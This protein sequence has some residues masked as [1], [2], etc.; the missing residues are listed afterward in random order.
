MKKSPDPINRTVKFASNLFLWFLI[1]LSSYLYLLIDDIYNIKFSYASWW[2]EFYDI[3][4]TFLSGG[5]ISFIFYFLVVAVPEYRKKRIVKR[6]IQNIYTNVK[7]DIAYQIIFASQKG[8]RNDLQADRNTIEKV[9]TVSGFRE[10]FENGRESDEGF[11]AFRN[12]MSDDVPEFRE[13]IINLEQISK[14]IEFILHNYPISDPDAFDFFKYLELTL[15]RISKKGPGYEEEKEL[16]NFIWRVFGG[17]NWIEGPRDYDPIQR[18]I[19][20]I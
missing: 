16:S 4:T 12:Y 10:L 13:I 1:T 14:Q 8:G 2:P 18:M 17:S 20:S 5:L 6:N 7:Y 9:L 3:A 19:D 11:Y 15:L